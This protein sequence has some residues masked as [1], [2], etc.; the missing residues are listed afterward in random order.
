MVAVSRDTGGHMRI[1]TLP[2]GALLVVA[3]ITLQSG[4]VDATWEG[5]I[6]SVFA[7]D[8]KARADLI[9]TKGA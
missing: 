9:Q 1:V 2:A 3:T 6:V 7:Q 5:Q 8:L 4:L